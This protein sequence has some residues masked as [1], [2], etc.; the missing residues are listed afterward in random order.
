MT[1]SPYQIAAATSPQA[2]VNVVAG[3][4]SGKT[5]VIVERY[6]HMLSTGTAPQQVVVITFTV[7]AGNELKRRIDAAGLPIPNFVGTIHSYCASLL[8][9][10]H[11]GTSLASQEIADS[12]MEKVEAMFPKEKV[13]HLDRTPIV[14]LEK[15]RVYA[16]YQAHMRNARLVDFRNL[17]V[18][19]NRSE[20][21]RDLVRPLHV[22]VDEFQDTTRD[23]RNV[24]EMFG[25]WF[26]VGDPRQQL[27]Q[28]RG[29]T[30]WFPVHNLP[31]PISYRVPKAVG[32][33]VNRIRF[34][35][36]EPMICH[37][38][39]GTAKIGDA[40][41]LVKLEGTK[42]L[43]VRTNREV[44]HWVS[45][46]TA[47]GIQVIRP[48]PVPQDILLYAD[49]L[50][51]HLHPKSLYIVEQYLK[52]EPELLKKANELAKHRLS[53]L[54]DVVVVPEKYPFP[55]TPAIT[56][57]EA[58]YPNPMDRLIAI[59]QMRS[60]L[61]EGDGVRV[62]TIHGFKGLEADHVC[63]VV[64][65]RLKDTLEDRC[66]MYVAMTRCRQTL[67]M[68]RKNDPPGWLPLP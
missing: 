7:A 52:R 66:L 40:L 43:L 39:G 35:N 17:I 21:A 63:V 53:K 19:F 36:M 68:D 30:E 18:G 14:E 2:V 65:E 5:A 67:I 58:Q 47:K 54:T 34:A 31:I 57:L 16:A 46:L 37:N 51:A 27:Y 64:P 11:P 6:R 3:A 33:L 59:R 8:P 23:E 13:P 45:K 41:D 60:V 61:P 20:L 62:S 25:T 26:F 56:N 38:D 32:E 10:T 9:F 29:A 48:I 22:I 24:V 15:N 1:L 42:A 55:V 4:G 28:F 12:V 49:W 50:D 44:E